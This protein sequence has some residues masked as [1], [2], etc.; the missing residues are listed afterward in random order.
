MKTLTTTACAIA[1]SLA[2][3]TT[4]QAAP[5]FAESVVSY[6]PG[7]VKRVEP[8]RADVSAV[9]GEEDGTFFSLGFGGSVVLAFAR[10]FRAI[11]KVFEVTYNDKSK[12]KETADVYASNDGVT[13]TL[14][15][16]LQNHLSTSF[17]NSG[18]FTLLKIVD[19][20]KVNAPTFDG[21]DVDAVSVSPV[22]V[23]AAGLLLGGALLG[24]GSL[25]R[26]RKA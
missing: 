16:S 6:T 21:F 22:P 9:L 18:I 1:L 15:A 19:T 25:R 14:I 12:H 23:P 2:A 5:I 4:S 3:V 8:G 11:G 24:L 7:P 13:W 20:S 26:R 10:P 17:S